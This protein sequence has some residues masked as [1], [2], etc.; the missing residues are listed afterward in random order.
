MFIF[1][2]AETAAICIPTPYSEAVM[3]HEVACVD[4][5][6]LGDERRSNICSI[7]LWVDIS[8]R[9][10]SLPALETMHIVP[11]PGGVYVT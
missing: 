5:T 8:I 4:V 10:L 3:E 1:H 9:I 6:P 11:I 7:G 2:L